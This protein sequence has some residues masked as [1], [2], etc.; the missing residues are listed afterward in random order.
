MHVDAAGHA[1]G[2]TFLCPGCFQKNNGPVGTHTIVVWNKR[3]PD[4]IS[5]VKWDFTGDTLD[6]LTITPSIDTR[7]TPTCSAHF[8]VKHGHIIIVKD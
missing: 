5:K 4:D 1:N 2:V 8:W 7:T 3:C 6:S